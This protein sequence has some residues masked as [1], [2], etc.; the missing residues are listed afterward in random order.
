[1]A[2]TTYQQLT[3]ATSEANVLAFVF[4]QLMGKTWSA[5]PVQVTAVTGG[6]GGLGVAG[7]V[8]VHPLVNQVDGSGVAT[9]HGTIHNLPYIRLQGGPNGIII[10]PAVGDIGLAVFCDR[11]ISSLKANKAQAN[12]GSWRR[13]SPSDGVYIGGILNAVVSQYLQFAGGITAGTPVLTTTGNV[14]VATGASGSFSSS[15]GQ[16][17]TVAD[18]II[19]SIA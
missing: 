17:I 5:C 16:L 15:T 12:P 7:S 4:Q 11:D 14:K 10:D 2:A 19:V 8:D 6:G 9:P 3:S 1:V 13:Y 18:G